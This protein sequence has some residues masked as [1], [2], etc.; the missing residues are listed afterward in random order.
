MDGGTMRNQVDAVR[1]AM[2]Q[3]S[4]ARAEAGD[5]DANPGEVDDVER[6]GKRIGIRKR[7]QQQEL[8]V[9]VR[10]L[11]EGFNSFQ[12]GAWEEFGEDPARVPPAFGARTAAA[13]FL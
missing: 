11:G 5:G 1:Q 9:R 3:G 13:R 2:A 7:R 4:E 10:N 12:I 6:R 8:G